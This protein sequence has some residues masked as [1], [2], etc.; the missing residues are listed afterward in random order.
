MLSL[1]CLCDITISA[2]ACQ[3][4]NP[5]YVDPLFNYQHSLSWILLQVPA[6]PSPPHSSLCT[7]ASCK[8]KIRQVSLAEIVQY[9]MLIQHQQT[10]RRPLCSH[11]LWHKCVLVN[12]SSDT[13]CPNYTSQ[14]MSLLLPLSTVL[15]YPACYRLEQLPF[16]S[17]TA[18]RN[19]TL[20]RK[21]QRKGIQR[22]RY[23]KLIT[24]ETFSA[25]TELN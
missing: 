22:V 8:T 13:I 10:H 7:E 3:I 11:P 1:W 14:T 19:D 23:L 20:K 15:N 24:E 25:S 16:C 4:R 5:G 12:K 18:T 9:S 6:E 21:V 17:P 2:T